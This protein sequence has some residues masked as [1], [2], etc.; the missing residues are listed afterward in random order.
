MITK[1][2][3]EIRDKL[4]IGQQADA[5]LLGI[6]GMIGANALAGIPAI[7]ALRKSQPG[8]TGAEASRL[9]ADMAGGKPVRDLTISEALGFGDKNVRSALKKDKALKFVGAP[10]GISAYDPE[11]H[12]V[13]GNKNSYITA[14]ELGHATGLMGKNRALGKAM[15]LFSHGPFRGVPT[16]APISEAIRG[17]RKGYAEESGKP[18]QDSRMLDAA[19][20]VGRASTAAQL[21]EE[22]QASIRGL[23]AIGKIQ[24]RNGVIQA[25]K[26]LGPAFGTYLGA[27]AGSH[28]LAPYLG[29]LY[30]RSVAREEREND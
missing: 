14:H 30:G 24:G 4:S 7:S 20:Y 18:E 5:A 8:F 13:M 11:T 3:E 28:L 16:L 10:I 27:A 21:A 22:A 6:G 17:A 12:I 2:G 26:L 15:A 1:T 9:V 19:T 25:A 23:H 29:K